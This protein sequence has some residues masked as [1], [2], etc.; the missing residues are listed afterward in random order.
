M[1]LKG[2]GSE[3]RVFRRYDSWRKI[4]TIFKNLKNLYLQD[5]QERSIQ[6]LASKIQMLRKSFNIYVRWYYGTYGPISS[7]S[8]LV[9][10]LSWQSIARPE[11]SLDDDATGCLC[12][13]C[14]RWASISQISGS[15]GYLRRGRF[16][17]IPWKISTAWFELLCAPKF[18]F[19]PQLIDLLRWDVRN[20]QKEFCR[21]AVLLVI[22]H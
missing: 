20:D 21:N 11:K 3:W 13:N 2:Y 18:H 19:L 5:K 1:K 12:S 15:C 6:L 16:K 4:L 22:F 14:G 10:T 7:V 8:R 17:F 9:S